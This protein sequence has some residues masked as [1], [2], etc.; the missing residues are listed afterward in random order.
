LVLAQEQARNVVVG[1]EKEEPERIA[2][3]VEKLE[4]EAHAQISQADPSRP[5]SKARKKGRGRPEDG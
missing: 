1:L 5:R 4:K 2:Q 3:E